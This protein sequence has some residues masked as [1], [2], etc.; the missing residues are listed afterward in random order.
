LR[1]QSAEGRARVTPGNGSES[2]SAESGTR[3]GEPPRV[4][5][6]GFPRISQDAATC[7][8]GRITSKHK[9]TFYDELEF[10]KLGRC[11]RLAPLCALLAYVLWVSPALPA[12]SN[13]TNKA[14]GKGP[15][16]AAPGGDSDLLASNEVPRLRP[17]RGEIPPTFWEQYGGWVVA[18]AVVF[19][20]GG[21][22]LAWYLGRP[23]P[24]TP[25]PPEVAARQALEALRARAEDGRVL[26]QVSQVLRRYLAAVFRLP[27]A[28][29]TTTEFCRE[30]AGSQPVGPELAGAVSSFLRRCDERKFAPS[31]PG[32]ALDAATS[33]LGLVGQAE[34]R[35]AQLAKAAQDAA[36][37]AGK[38]ETR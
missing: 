24:S 8:A 13:S 20:V 23:A 18:G 22:T 14:E 7:A 6:S 30:L 16:P 28:E 9:K 37:M 25:I 17:V 35:R 32:A 2:D 31:A 27:P 5:T 29:L 1:V 3:L 33:A 38:G 4:R 21:G 26:S 36:A 10:P 11:Q 12:A 15:A 19:L 34:E